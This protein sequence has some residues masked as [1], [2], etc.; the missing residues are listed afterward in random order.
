M[1][2]YVVC[3]YTQASPH[4]CSVSIKDPW[5][6]ASALFPRQERSRR[7]GS[8]VTPSHAHPGGQ[9]TP[10]PGTGSPP[11]PVSCLTALGRGNSRGNGALPLDTSW[12]RCFTATGWHLMEA[13]MLP[14]WIWSW[15]FLKLNLLRES[16]FP[17]GMFAFY[18]D[19]AEMGTKSDL[20]SLILGC[21]DP[22]LKQWMH[23]CMWQPQGQ[24]SYP[25]GV[26]E[27]G[28]TLV[29]TKT[30][31]AIGDSGNRRARP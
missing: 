4:P 9:D 28:T 21:Y 19:W 15:P 5:A 14:G 27:P 18:Y 12:K 16:N 31:F 6:A 26:L 17:K 22:F 1:A 3:N 20:Q 25:S 30:S 24:G 8:G 7:H 11:L 23:V 10:G 2:L 13:L 29:A